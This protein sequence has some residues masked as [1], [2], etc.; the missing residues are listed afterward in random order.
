MITNEIIYKAAAAHMAW[1]T[2]LQ[3]VIE[4]HSSELTATESQN[5]TRCDFGKW[6]YSL[7]QEEQSTEYWKKTQKIHMEFHAEAGRILGLALAGK[8]TE[9]QEALTIQ[10][11]YG[12][13]TD[14]LLNTLN[15]WAKSV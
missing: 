9:A 13:L 11:K 1:K 6:L 15:Q 4:T 3:K 12:R 5:D 10:S 8:S 7:P 2:R 14:E